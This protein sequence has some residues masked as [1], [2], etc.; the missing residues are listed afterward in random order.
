VTAPK[1]NQSN[2]Y[3]SFFTKEAKDFTQVMAIAM[4]IEGATSGG[5]V[6]EHATSITAK[7]DKESEPWC[8]GNG[9]LFK[10]NPLSF[11]TWKSTLDVL[12]KPSTYKDVNRDCIAL[13]GKD[14]KLDRHDLHSNLELNWVHFHTAKRYLYHQPLQHMSHLLLSTSTHSCV[15]IYLHQW[16]W[17]CRN[18]QYHQFHLLQQRKPSKI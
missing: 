14:I 15:S 18:L 1:N 13:L 17:L 16:S 4:F 12:T 3:P 2:N 8:E 5:K 7:L 6:E 9:A 11:C 10:M